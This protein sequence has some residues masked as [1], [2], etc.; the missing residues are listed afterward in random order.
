MNVT[1]NRRKSISALTVV[2]GFSFMLMTGPALAQKV[3]I[4][5]DEKNAKTINEG[6]RNEY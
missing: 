1:R 3:T 5:F 6:V 2:L 4:D